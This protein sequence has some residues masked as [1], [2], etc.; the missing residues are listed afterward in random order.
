MIHQIFSVMWWISF[1]CWIL[2]IPIS[3]AKLYQSRTHDQQEL[4]GTSSMSV[5]EFDGYYSDWNTMGNRP[6]QPTC[7]EIP[8]NMSLCHN[9]G[10][11][12]MRLPNLLDHDT[13]NEALQQSSSWVPLQ[14][15]ECHPDTRLFLCSL[16]SP[17]CLD[18]PIYP[19]RSL[20]DK[21]REGCEGRMQLYGYPWPDMLKCDKFPLDND[22]CITAQSSSRPTNGQVEEPNACSACHQVPT[23][24]NIL[25]NFCRA[26]F[27]LKTK[28]RKI[29]KSRIICKK[30]KV[31][32]SGGS[33]MARSI[34]KPKLIL[35]NADECCNEVTKKLK[36]NYLI[37]GHK[38]GNDL[39]T[40]FIMEWAP[41]STAFKKAIKTFK[42]LDC[43]N[44]KIISETVVVDSTLTADSTFKSNT[45]ESLSGQLP[46]SMLM[47]NNRFS[48][49]STNNNNP[50]STLASAQPK[51]SR[52]S[53]KNKK[54]TTTDQLF[55]M[56]TSNVT[57]VGNR[58]PTET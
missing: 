2:I 15:I 13:L 21:V 43:S 23:Y 45:Q 55:S 52:K 24:E 37:M 28:I 48:S 17:V 33:T 35:N 8:K 51:R 31:F 34:R 16:F 54:S 22:M 1:N 10:Y 38:S 39:V 27:A 57:F 19:C 41:D 36:A 42:K 7:V 44:P 46:S 12:K 6:T 29:R 40:T 56:S 30:S 4:P 3:A 53:N 58:P 11:T 5:T 9:I 50:V 25:D 26:D 32:K 47:N 14:K 18:R 49:Q 20:C